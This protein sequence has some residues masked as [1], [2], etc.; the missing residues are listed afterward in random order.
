M[1][2]ALGMK[3]KYNKLIDSG[4]DE[5]ESKPVV[6]VKPKVPPKPRRREESSSSHAE[7]ELPK[8][9]AKPGTEFHYR[10]L[11]DEYGSRPVAATSMSEKRKDHDVIS[12]ISTSSQEYDAA[13]KTMSIVPNPGKVSTEQ[14]DDEGEEER[15]SPVPA[16][17]IIGH[18]HGV[19]PLLDDDELEN[20]YGN[21]VHSKSV[22][23]TDDAGVSDMV[24][25]DSISPELHVNRTENVDIFGAAPFRRKSKKRTPTH[26]LSIPRPYHKEDKLKMVSPIPLVSKSKDKIENQNKGDGPNSR[27]NIG[28]EMTSLISSREEGNVDAEYIN[29]VFGSIPFVKGP[30]SMEVLPTAGSPSYDIGGG[31]KR[32]SSYSDKQVRS[33]FSADSLTQKGSKKSSDI[34]GS[35]PFS[36]MQGQ[37]A[38]HKRDQ[39]ISDRTDAPHKVTTDTSVIYR[40]SLVTDATDKSIDRFNENVTFSSDYQRF[41]DSDSEETGETTK[42][43]KSKGSKSPE[44]PNIESSAF[45]NMS[46]NDD[47]EE[48]E[49]V[50]NESLDRLTMSPQDRNGHNL[51]YSQSQILNVSTIR[52]PVYAKES[53][54]MVNSGSGEALKHNSDKYDTFTWPRKRLKGHVHSRATAEPFTVKK[55]VDI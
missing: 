30:S 17:P 10:E 44:G 45:S 13:V 54:S 55:K 51:K 46:F 4:D 28:S 37:Y 26:L 38:V 8:D 31:D 15:I 12:M 50:L 20:A 7:E 19:R 29:D 40:K 23:T 14:Q 53:T 42:F 43:T 3:S 5:E 36:S 47:F 27:S 1:K 49:D 6:K 22:D 24:K 39:P 11:D 16:D 32:D 41:D 35:V 33:S 18:E 34:F 9:Q 21:Q 25:S 48:E 52:H 2:A